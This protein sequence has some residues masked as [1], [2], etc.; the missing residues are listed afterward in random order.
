M[1]TRWFFYKGEWEIKAELGD[2]G[3]KQKLTLFN[4]PSYLG[5]L[6]QEVNRRMTKQ[7]NVYVVKLVDYELP[8]SMA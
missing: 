7:K 8:Y 4:G 6:P 3:R 1:T 2:H 5:H